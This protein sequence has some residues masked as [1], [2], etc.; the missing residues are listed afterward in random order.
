MTLVSAAVAYCRG[1]C[2]PKL[3]AG[4]DLVCFFGHLLNGVTD[5]ALFR[6]CSLSPSFLTRL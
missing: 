6:I 1:C 4:L 3:A 5:F 2:P